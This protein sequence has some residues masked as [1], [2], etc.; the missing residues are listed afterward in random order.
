MD[1]ELH[2]KLEKLKTYLQ[3]LGSVAIGFSGGVDS[4]FLLFISHEVLGENAIA[5]TAV[6]GSVPEREIGGAIDFCDDIGVRHI[7][8]NVNPLKIE[9]YRL[10]APDRCYHCKKE[11]FT[12]IKKIAK[13]NGIKYVA[14]GSN[15]DDL[16]DYRPGLK[17]IEELSVCSPLRECNL[18]KH[19]IRMLS[20]EFGLRT[21][22]KPSYACLASRFVYGEEITKE[23]LHMIDEAE[24]FLIENGFLEERVR[25]HGKMARIEVNPAD[26]QR[27]A[28]DSMRERVYQRFREIGF[29]YVTLDLCGYRTG[30]MNAVLGK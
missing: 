6:D 17:A 28:G 30:S 15:V 3:E 13:E 26:I 22:S 2:N 29:L 1:I 9:Q 16:G 18:T 10:N 7:T 4:S 12:D 8:C 11:I 19:D 25:M 21:W 24:Q 5:V 27:L 14:E 20:K 23:K